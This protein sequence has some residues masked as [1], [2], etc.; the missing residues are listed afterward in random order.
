MQLYKVLD[1]SYQPLFH[2]VPCTITWP[3]RNTPHT[4]GTQ[5]PRAERVKTAAV[6]MSSAG[7]AH[8]LLVGVNFCDVSDSCWV[9]AQAKGALVWHQHIAVLNAAACIDLAQGSLDAAIKE[10]EVLR[11]LCIV[12]LDVLGSPA[13]TETCGEPTAEAAQGG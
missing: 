3:D 10:C 4:S 13:D 7:S 1:M 6:F 11:D 12:Q 5:Q 9:E 2:A 8:L